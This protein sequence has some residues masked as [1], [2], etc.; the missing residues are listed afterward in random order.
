MYSVLLIPCAK[1]LEHCHT[2]VSLPSQNNVFALTE[3]AGHAGLRL[4][5]LC[6]M[7]AFTEAVGHA[8]VRLLRQIDVLALTEAAGHAGVRLL[9]LHRALPLHSHHTSLPRHHEQAQ[10]RRSRQVR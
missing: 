4:L 8:G 3:A 9:R 1:K 7:L 5:R 2:S 10:C 6:I